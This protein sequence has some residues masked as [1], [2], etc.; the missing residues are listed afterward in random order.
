MKVWIHQ[1]KSAMQW[2]QGNYKLLKEEWE[3]EP[4]QARLDA[5][6]KSYGEFKKLEGKYEQWHSDEAERNAE[7]ESD[8]CTGC[9][10]H[11][12]RCKLL[13]ECL[14]VDLSYKKDRAPF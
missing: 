7:D 14:G 6:V 9:G 11:S 5:Y 12:T 8:V 4:T 3:K 2:Q 1:I 13:P 10:Y